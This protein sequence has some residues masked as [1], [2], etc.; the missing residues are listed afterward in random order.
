PVE[1]VYLGPEAGEEERAL[2]RRCSEAGL[3]VFDLEA[4]VL[5]RVAATVN[6]QPLLAV[7]RRVDIAFDTLAG[8]HPTLVVVCVE[9]RDPGNAG[10][11][12]R[13]AEAAGSDGVIFCEGTVDLFN[14]KTVRASAGA[15][16]HVPV[17]LA[18][19]AA[20]ETL[21]L[22]WEWGLVRLGLVASGGEGYDSAD[23]TQPLAIVVGNEANGLAPELRST[24]DRC[25]SIPMPGRAESL[26]VSMA[27][28]VMC[29]EAARQRRAR[30]TAAPAAGAAWG[31]R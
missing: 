17:A 21:A 22:V 1:S 29:F 6:P 10:T 11:I 23:L 7:V 19:G 30:D 25:L 9:V 8:R 15:L 20:A 31:Q 4:G 24:L 27:A 28:T 13:S 16:F 14:P 26:N 3:R 5:E 18:A 12:L 2:A